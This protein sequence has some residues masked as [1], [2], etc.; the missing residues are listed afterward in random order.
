MKKKKIHDKLYDNDK[1]IRLRLFVLN[2]FITE[3]IL[4]VDLIEII[5]TGY[6]DFLRDIILLG[7]VML[8]VL[9]AS[10]VSVKNN[11]IKAG[12]AIICFIIGFI[13][14][15]MSFIFGGGINSGA[16]IWFIYIILLISL[17]LSGK[18]RIVFFV[19]ELLTATFCYYLGIFHPEFIHKNSEL[20]GGIFAFVSLVIISI[21][22]SILVSL[23]INL[24]VKEKKRT[25]EQKKEIEMLNAAQNQFFSSMSHEIRTPINTIIGLNEMILRE[26]INDEVVEDA[27]NIRSAGKL[28]LNLINDIL[29]MSKFKSGKMHLLIAPYHTGNML[30]DL[31]GM[32]WIRAKEKNL[33]FQ[34]N[35]SPDVPAELVGD[36]VRIKQILINILNNAIKYT[37]EGSISLTVQ[38][39]RID[40]ETFNIIYTVSDTGIGIKKEDIPFLFSAFKR[41]DEDVNNHIE[42]TGLGLSIVKQFLDLMGGKIAVNSV[43]TKGS[44]FIVE[45]PQRAVSDK[46]IGEYD[47][48]KSHGIGKKSEYRQKF[49]APEARIL[50]V[51]DNEANLMV[52][53]K[54]LRDT[55]V[56]IDTVKSGEAA[57]KKTQNIEYN[58]IFMDHLMPEMDGIECKK[59]IRNQTGG[60]SRDSKIVILTANA[61]EENRELY[62]KENFDGYL[63]KPVSADDLESEL[64]RHLP[65]DIVKVMGGD[66]EILK[67][68]IS[69][70]RGNQ[71]RKMVAISTESVAD[72]PREYIEKYDIAILPHKVRTREGTFKDGSEIDTSGVIKY[73]EDTTTTIMPMGPDSKEH[74]AFFA[75]QLEYANN[76]VH[77]SIS[78]K[79]ENSGCPTAIEAA[80]AFE[81][82]FVF[83]SGHL[84]SGQ[85]LLVIE[86]CRLAESGLGPRHIIERLEEIKNKIHTSFIVDNLDYLARSKQVNGRTAN[87]VK[88]L[89]GR[90]VLVLKKGRMKLGKIYFGSSVSA[91]RYYI[92]SC[93]SVS[94]RIDNRVLFITY[95]GLNKKEMD[96]IR[97]YISKKMDFDEIYFEQA[98]A[99]IAVNCGPGTF[100]LLFRDK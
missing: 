23:E 62:A 61:G 63:V 10:I 13:F 51:D 55:K 90:P 79:I 3:I 69:W 39:E 60:S 28:L 78:S 76:V 45:I 89:M 70:M 42:G 31:V 83:D 1:D 40:N 9:I 33:K 22:T 81:N 100:G 96:W 56:V 87:L 32:L 36:E 50:I 29:D 68:T 97:D 84:S 25:E 17:L 99:S 71:K 35:V 86:A 48:E 15:P 49:E 20:Q 58:V 8:F 7:A 67:E 16:P 2:A 5:L 88:S 92:N 57:L 27:V 19:L 66:G 6:D 47:F 59:R 18:T 30:S 64:L 11:H 73:M 24:F 43:Y 21:A 95:V 38:C 98:C 37:K 72:L 75:K 41:V 12:S 82:V 53:A 80:K 14:F 34:I 93:L 65:K 94:S 91:W 74:E 54:L 4:G 26:N 85:G 44:T 77:I 52:A 46:Q